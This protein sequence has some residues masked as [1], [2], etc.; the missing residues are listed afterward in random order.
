LLMLLTVLGQCVL[1]VALLVIVPLIMFRRDGLK[2]PGSAR[3][4]LYFCGLGAGYILIEVAAMQRF[5]LFLGHP[6]YAIT[7][8]LISFLVFSA[9]G[10]AV[11]GKSTDPRRT[12]LRAL[13]AVLVLLVIFV[14]G[15]PILFDLALKLPI[16]Q[17]I[18]VTVVA[19][20]P[21]AFFMGM[22]FPSG[23]A[24]VQK[25]AQQLVPWAFGVNGGAAVLAS[26]VGI[27][28]AMWGGFSMS[29][30]AAGVAYLLALL[31]GR[32]RTA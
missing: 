23:L 19:L 4:V 11:A 16:G 5:V 24:V 21:M 14:L 17:R 3:W 1:L 30:T 20:A 28:L 31:A 15:L 8:V 29:F 9:I 26:I 10:A 27:L 13:F 7:V 22:P 32:V 12:L 18:A 6:G 2:V 25:Q